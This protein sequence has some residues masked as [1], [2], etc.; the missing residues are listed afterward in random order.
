MDY[1]DI[2]SVEQ[3]EEREEKQ[4]KGAA[5]S[6]DT[7]TLYLNEIGRIPVLSGEEEYEIAKKAASGDEEARSRLV[8]ANL[9]LSVMVAKHFL[10]RGLE[11]MDLVQEGNIGL[12]QAARK[13]DPE[14]GYRF[15]SYA[16]PSIRSAITRALGEQGSEI[17]IPTYVLET[18]RAVMSAERELEEMLG[19]TPRPFEIASRLHMEEKKVI[20]ILT[21]PTVTCSIDRSVGEAGDAALGDFIADTGSLQPEEEMIEGDMQ[22]LVM[23]SLQELEPR[24]KE[25]VICRFGLFG[26]KKQTLQELADRR[27]VTR[28]RI[29]QIENAAIKKLKEA[30]KGFDV[31]YFFAS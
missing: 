2:I 6:T 21:L 24:E 7:T 29:R 5:F 23:R 11:F 14:K 19:R 30:L 31:N 28:E 20:D 16:V 3:K 10:G 22:A 25:V 4:E 17:R 13:F 8:E 9:R 18:Q 15:S 27:S 26:C 1:C 12:M